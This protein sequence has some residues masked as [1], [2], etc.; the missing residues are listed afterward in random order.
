MRIFNIHGYHG[1]PQNVAAGAMQ[2]LGHDVITPSIDYDAY[3]PEYIAGELGYMVQEAQPDIM[4]G[5]SLG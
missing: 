2:E 4:V 1:S 5:T 3:N